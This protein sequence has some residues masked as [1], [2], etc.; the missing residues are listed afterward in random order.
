M[1]DRYHHVALELAALFTRFGNGLFDGFR[2]EQLHDIALF[3][4]A[5]TPDARSTENEYKWG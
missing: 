4:P 2:T 5:Y 1:M 3:S